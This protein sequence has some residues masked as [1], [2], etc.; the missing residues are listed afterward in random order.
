MEGPWLWCLRMG[1]CE[2]WPGSSHWWIQCISWL[3]V[4]FYGE[5]DSCKLFD[6]ARQEISCW[7][8]SLINAGICPSLAADPF[9]LFHYTLDEGI[10]LGFLEN[11][12]SMH[13]LT[14]TFKASSSLAETW[15]AGKKLQA[16]GSWIHQSKCSGLHS[17]LERYS[18]DK[19]V[20]WFFITMVML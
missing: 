9:E 6:S 15:S 4:K 20:C 11:A 14:Q 5:P 1:Q 18:G 13:A 8:I 3:Y 12:F 10:R 7:V 17:A 16:N 19:A 2:S